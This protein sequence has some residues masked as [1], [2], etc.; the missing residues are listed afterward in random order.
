MCVLGVKVRLSVSITR[1]SAHYRNR[2]AVESILLLTLYSIF[3]TLVAMGGKRRGAPGYDEDF[4]FV[5][6][7]VKYLLFIFNFIFW[8]SASSDFQVLFLFAF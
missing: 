3:L 5:S 2:C 1:K 8:V 6:P 7:V 4:S